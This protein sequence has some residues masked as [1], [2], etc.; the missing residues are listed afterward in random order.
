MLPMAE[1][2][3]KELRRVAEEVAVTADRKGLRQY[4]V[5]NFSHYIYAR[6]LREGIESIV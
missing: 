6:Q 4:V 1:P 5:D 3:P 2:D